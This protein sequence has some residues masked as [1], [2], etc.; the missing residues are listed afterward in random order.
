MTMCLLSVTSVRLSHAGIV[1]K[2][3]NVLKG[4]SG[5]PKYSLRVLPSRTF[6]LLHGDRRK[7][8]QLRWTL[9][10]INWRRSSVDS[11]SHW[12][13]SF[14]YNTM[15]VTHASRRS[16][17]GSWDL[18]QFICL[19]AKTT[20][21]PKIHQT[22]HNYHRLRGSASPVLTATGFVNGKGQLLPATESTPLNRSPKKLSQVITS[23]T[24]TAVPN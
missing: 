13:S 21:T 16:V 4:N 15:S 20:L 5:I 6:F 18:L 2:R 10:V 19:L 23:A 7:C 14:V 11:L 22:L 1:S 17:C 12:A 9:S 24:P 8:C 3:L